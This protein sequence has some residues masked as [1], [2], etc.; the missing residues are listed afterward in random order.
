MILWTYTIICDW[1]G[2]Q[3]PPPPREKHDR[4][5]KPTNKK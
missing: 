5:I 3:A 2:K 1:K 4:D